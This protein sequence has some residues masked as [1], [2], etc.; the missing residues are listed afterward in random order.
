METKNTPGDE[1]PYAAAIEE[2]ESILGRIEMPNVDVDV[3]SEAVE[4]AAFLL[5][6]C[7][8]RIHK[9]ETKINQVLFELEKE[10]CLDE[11]PSKD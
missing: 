5:G 8:K 2:L 11:E 7:R 6:V 10:E 3:L 9:A 4:R 1:I